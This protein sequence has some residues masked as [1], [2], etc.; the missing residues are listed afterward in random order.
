MHCVESCFNFLKMPSTK[1][2]LRFAIM[3]WIRIM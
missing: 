2:R 3:P 1:N